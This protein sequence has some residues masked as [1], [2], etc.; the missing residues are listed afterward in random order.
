MEVADPLGMADGAWVVESDGGSTAVVRDAAGETPD[1]RL[2]A[3]DLASIYLGAV[4]P[5]TLAAAG[6]IKEKRPRAALQA[7][8]L[9]AVERSAH[10]MTHF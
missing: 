4:S 5:V 6:R 2:D 3:A 8:Q 1:L 7:Q 9:F 10:C